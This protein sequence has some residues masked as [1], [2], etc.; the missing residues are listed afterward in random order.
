VRDDTQ[1]AILARYGTVLRCYDNGGRTMDRYTIVPPRWASEYRQRNG[2]WCA[3]GA[4][5]EPGHPQGFGQSTTAM[6]GPHLGKRVSWSAL[7]A[8]VQGFARWTFPDYAP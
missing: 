4:S 7:P 5:E 6:P 2:A 1:G 3:I 8:G